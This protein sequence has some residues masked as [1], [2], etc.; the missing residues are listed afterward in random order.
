MW[1]A[2]NL[3][4]GA[5]AAN[6]TAATFVGAGL[7]FDDLLMRNARGQFYRSVAQ[8]ALSRRGKKQTSSS[9]LSIIAKV[10][11]SDMDARVWRRL[12]E[13][14]KDVGWQEGGWLMVVK[15]KGHNGSQHR[16]AMFIHRVAELKPNSDAHEH[17]STIGFLNTVVQTTFSVLFWSREAK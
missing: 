14:C 5:S 3:L 6:T 13:A 16:L 17:F 15:N 7:S 11:C 12:G 4:A 2:K 8:T 1:R 9:D 10:V